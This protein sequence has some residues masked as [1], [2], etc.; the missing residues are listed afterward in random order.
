MTPH[1]QTIDNHNMRQEGFYVSV[2]DGK[3][4]GFLLGPYPTHDEALANVD[5]GKSL[6]LA[7]NDDPSNA[8]WWYAYGTCRLERATLPS[9][10]FG[11]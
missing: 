1:R 6:A 7:G 2:V 10:V 9:G 11:R 8:A 3:R 4:Y 5:R